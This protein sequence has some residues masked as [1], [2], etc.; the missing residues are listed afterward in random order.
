VIEKLVQDSVVLQGSRDEGLLSLD[1]SFYN[2]QSKSYSKR[3]KEITRAKELINSRMDNVSGEIITVWFHNNE[4]SEF[5]YERGKILAKEKID[6]IYKKVTS[7]E[8]TMLQAKN[9]LLAD[10]DIKKLD[11]S[12]YQTN[13]YMEFKDVQ[14]G[15]KITADKVFDSTIRLTKV[16]TYTPIVSIQGKARGTNNQTIDL[17]YAFAYVHSRNEVSLGGNYDAWLQK[18]KSKYKVDNR[19]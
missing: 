4:P 9:T 16:G 5:G 19:K 15:Q 18:Y 3:L 6:A 2:S 17:L 8:L 11:P 13:L 12:A 14:S 10:P 1:S 7:G